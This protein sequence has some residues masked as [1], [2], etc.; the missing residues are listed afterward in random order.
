M[1]RGQ[2]GQGWVSETK[3]TSSA[4]AHMSA[5]RKPDVLGKEYEEAAQELNRMVKRAR[6]L[7]EL[8]AALLALDKEDPAAAAALRKDRADDIKEAR[9]FRRDNEKLLRL[10]PT[11]SRVREELG[12]QGR[13][14]RLQEA[15]VLDKNKRSTSVDT[16]DENI[17]KLK[18]IFVEK[19]RKA[20]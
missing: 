18:R 8:R 16:L 10:Y 2:S 20:G 13:N 19:Y 17:E 11:Y 14:K 3:S 7:G 4:G 9:T 1:A 12:A 15:Y 6:E 5:A